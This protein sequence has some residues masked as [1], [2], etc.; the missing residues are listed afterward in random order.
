MPTA[1]PKRN[2]HVVPA[3]YLKGFVEKPGEPFIWMY[4][5]GRCY[6][7]GK[8]TQKN[9][10]AYTSIRI[11][12][13]ERDFYTDSQPGVPP[14]SET[15]ENLL[16]RL[17]K[18]ADAIFQKIRS[19]QNITQDD[20]LIF[21]KYIVQM[22]K[23]T[24][25]TRSW[26]EDHMPKYLAAY[27][28]DPN[29]TE[30]IEGNDVNEK[31]SKLIAILDRMK[32]DPNMSRGTHL[33]TLTLIEQ[34]QSI[35]AINQMTWCFWVASGDQAF[36]T[37]DNPVFIF[38][39]LGLAKP[40]S[41][42]NFPISSNVALWGSNRRDLRSGYFPAEARLVKEFNRRTAKNATRHV[43]ASCCEEWIL[44]LLNKESHRVGLL[45]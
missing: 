34:A 40:E 32:A 1:N 23:R 14:D 7:P 31:R 29:L 13:V 36:L 30:M 15:Y 4:T 42:L 10:P 20:K 19:H 33:R 3:L 21:S 17:E 37:G 16:E 45:R 41:E 44:N 11:A 12:G 6:S 43:Y 38:K 9:C 22:M 28:D 35:K 24:E 27:Y 5:K 39:Q 25:E 8:H 2:H 26:V 18:P